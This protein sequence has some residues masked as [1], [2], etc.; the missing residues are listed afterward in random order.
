VNCIGDLDLLKF[1]RGGGIGDVFGRVSGRAS[2]VFA[3]MERR[4][5]GR[6]GFCLSCA[7]TRGCS[8]SGS[9]SSGADT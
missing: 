6:T 7:C 8:D 1:R 5:G 3:F 2:S 9:C 4:G